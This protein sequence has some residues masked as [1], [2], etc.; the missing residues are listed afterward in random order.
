MILEG[1]EVLIGDVVH[2]ILLGDGFVE[3]V[4]ITSCQVKFTERRLD[5]YGNGLWGGTKRLYWRNPIYMIPT[6]NDLPVWELSKTIVETI[7][8]FQG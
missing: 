1:S 8:A 3:A 7:Q 6:K 5:Y 2:D 4:G